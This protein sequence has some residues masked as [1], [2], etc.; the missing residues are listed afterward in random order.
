MILKILFGLKP[1]IPEDLFGTTFVM[2]KST[3]WQVDASS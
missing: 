3:Q 1:E 2:L